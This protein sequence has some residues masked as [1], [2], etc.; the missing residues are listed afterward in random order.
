MIRNVIKKE[1]N[2]NSGKGDVTERISE[3]A[4]SNFFTEHKDPS[5]IGPT[6]S[7]DN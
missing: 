2:V 6:N 1:V 7:N 5:W 3:E 4:N